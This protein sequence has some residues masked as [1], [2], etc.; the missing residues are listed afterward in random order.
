MAAAWAQVGD[1]L[2]AEAALQRAA[3]TRWAAA[4]FYRRSVAVMSDDRLLTLAAP[5]AAVTPFAGR[6]LTGHHPPDLP[7]GRC[8]RRRP[9]AHP[10]TIGPGGAVG[11]PS[12]RGGCGAGAHR[13]RVDPGRRHRGR[14]C[15]P[16]RPAGALRCPDAATAPGDVMAAL[17]LPISLPAE[18]TAGLLE[19]ARAVS[20]TGAPSLGERLAPRA[21]LRSTGVPGQAHLDAARRVAS[22]TASAVAEAESPAPDALLATAAGATLD[23]ILESLAE[24][25]GGGEPGVGLLIE[26]PRV[27]PDSGATGRPAVAVLDLDRRGIAGGAHPGG[28]PQRAG[29]QRRAERHAS[30][31]V[32]AARAP[33]RMACLP[34]P[35][36]RSVRQR[37]R[38]SLSRRLHRAGREPSRASRCRVSVRA[39]PRGSPRPSHRQPSHRR[40]L[41]PRQAPPRPAEAVLTVTAASVAPGARHA[42]PAGVGAGVAGLGD[43]PGDWQ[44]R[45]PSGALRPARI[46]AG[47]PAAH[48]SGGGAVAAPRR[49]RHPGRSGGGRLGPCRRAC[50]GWLVGDPRDRSGDGLPNLHRGLPTPTSPPTTAP[51]SAPASTRCRRNRS[52]CWRPIPA[53]SPG[54]WPG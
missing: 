20:G 54:S 53:S 36:E 41:H 30:R 37:C 7:A 13:A 49:S 10:G 29:G 39:A 24:S 4:A 40:S 28:R 18:R 27:V 48:R 11:R 19:A 47:H 44:P 23:G 3:L 32:R 21:D 22:A 35:G 42:G 38:G 15:H 14:R 17:G 25:P 8:P 1:V 51:G 6:A 26:A 52:P 31:G 45:R 46:D 2:A 33:R 16:I 43:R 9:A 50:R 5:L 34:G 12:R